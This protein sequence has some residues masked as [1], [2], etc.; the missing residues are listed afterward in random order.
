MPIAAENALP[1]TAAWWEAPHAP[2]AAIEGFATETS[3]VAGDVLGLSVSTQ[4]AARYVGRVFRLGWYAGLGGRLL[5]TLPGNVGLPRYAPPPD[6]VTGYCRADWPV[7]DRVLSSEDWPSGQYIA[8]LELVSGPHAGTALRIPFVVRAVPGRRAPILVQIPVNTR[9]AYNHW[10]GKSLYESSSTD[11]IAAVKVSFD[12]P[13]HSWDEAAARAGKLANLNSREPFVYELPLIRWLER[14]GFEVAYQT[15]VDTHRD[16][17]SL[18]GPRLLMTAGHDEYWTLEM[19]DGFDEALS[20]GVS[21]AFMGANTCYWQIR[22][23]DGERTLAEYRRADTDPEPDPARKTVRFRDLT[24][25]RPERELI[26]QQ[27]DGGLVKPRDARAFSFVQSFAGD[28]WAA[29]IELNF[30]A[31]LERLVGYE[32]DTLDERAVPPGCVRI[33]HC[34]G[35]DVAADCIRWTAPSGGRVFSSG[36]LGFSWGLDDWASPGTADARIQGLMLNGLREMLA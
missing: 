4:P 26:G 25:P 21:L 24:P 8:V 9:Q 7:T 35:P 13:M 20:R 6:P 34:D 31:P 32:W 30:P 28:A 29:G 16:P 11:Q 5:Q 33:L 1:G 22:Y 14:E 19:R 2:P 3:V 12:R 27:Y 18:W 17:S 15:N 10:G 23:E 36:S